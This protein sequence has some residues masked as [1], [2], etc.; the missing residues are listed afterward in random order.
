MRYNSYSMQFSHLKCTSQWFLVPLQSC[1]TITTTNFRT[2]KSPNIEIQYPELVT[3]PFPST[4]SVLGSQ[5]SV[6]WFYL[7]AYYR[8]FI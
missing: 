4:S 5:S 2:F 6:F 3:P 7:F 1:A 8:Y